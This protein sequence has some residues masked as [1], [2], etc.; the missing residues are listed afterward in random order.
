MIKIILL[1]IA[2]TITFSAPAAAHI[3][4][5]PQFVLINY[6]EQKHGEARVIT[7]IGNSGWPIE[8]WSSKDGKTWSI[9]TYRPPGQACLMATG[10]DSIEIKWISPLGEPA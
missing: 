4:C 3:K 2:L 9:V 5:W 7:A 1:V 10:V 6:L 8:W